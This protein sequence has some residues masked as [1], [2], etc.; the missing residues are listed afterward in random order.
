MRSIE[1]LWMTPHGPKAFRFRHAVWQVRSILDSWRDVGQWWR[2]EPELWFWRVEVQNGG[3]YELAWD[4]VG[5][6]SWIYRVYD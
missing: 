5:G 6:H 3:I 1:E 4:P 2:Q